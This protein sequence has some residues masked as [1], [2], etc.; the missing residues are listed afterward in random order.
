[1]RKEQYK[2]MRHRHTIKIAGSVFMLTTLIIGMSMFTQQ[3][4][5]R[6]SLRL[7][8]LIDE[9][10]KNARIEEWDAAETNLKKVNDVWSSVKGLWSAL[11]DHQEIDNIDIT[12]SRLQ[13]L[14]QSKEI[15][16][17]LSEA[18]ALRKYI[19]HIPAK[20][21]LGFENLF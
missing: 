9:I 3:I 15:P 6:D 10:E 11:I 2:T 12:L 8:Q 14:V 7:E 13:M 16:S 18:A 5:S 17:L 21:K 19:G 4:L 1:M 20:E